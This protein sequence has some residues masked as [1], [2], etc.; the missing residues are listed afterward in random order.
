VKSDFIP[1]V[2]VSMMLDLEALLGASEPVR[3]RPR[4]VR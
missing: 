2:A 3:Y 1:V 4:L